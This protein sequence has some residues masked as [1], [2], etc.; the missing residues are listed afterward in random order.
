MALLLAK[1]LAVA[2]LAGA[3]LELT[4]PRFAVAL[5]TLA[6]TFWEASVVPL[7]PAPRFAAACE[8]LPP[9]ADE[10]AAERLY[11]AL[12]MPV[13]APLKKPVPAPNPFKPPIRAAPPK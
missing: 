5:A 3:T 4:A 11:H 12:P 7:A 13:A 2:W 10:P 9:K 8:K 1:A 6:A